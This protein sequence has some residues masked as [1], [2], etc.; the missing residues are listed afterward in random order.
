MEV[1]SLTTAAAFLRHHPSAT[2]TI[3]I[4]PLCNRRE[5]VLALAVLVRRFPEA[6][7]V[8]LWGDLARCSRREAQEWTLLCHAVGGSGVGVSR[9]TL[10][11]TNESPTCVEGGATSF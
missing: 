11:T 2:L 4:D 10:P 3:E 6:H 9:R 7:L 1:R 5:V 8:L